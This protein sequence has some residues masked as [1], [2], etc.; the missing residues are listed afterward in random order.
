[1]KG[2]AT[3]GARNGASKGFDALMRECGSS[4]CNAERL[5]GSSAS[6]E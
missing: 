2:F 1:M 4:Q 3:G 6:D 5:T